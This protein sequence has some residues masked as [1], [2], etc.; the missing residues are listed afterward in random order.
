MNSET[1]GREFIATIQKES[2]KSLQTLGAVS[3]TLIFFQKP[4]VEPENIKK[5]KYPRFVGQLKKD[6]SINS[7]VGM[8]GGPIFGFNLNPPIR[9]WVVAIQSSWLKDRR[10]TFGCPLPVLANL[11]TEWTEEVLKELPEGEKGT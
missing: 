11:L 2:D 8:S 6:I 4:S 3:P 5:T 7:I 1:L 9:Y 10:I